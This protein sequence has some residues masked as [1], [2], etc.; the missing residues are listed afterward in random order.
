MVECRP[1]PKIENHIALAKKHLDHAIQLQSETCKDHLWS[2]VALFYALT[3]VVQAKLIQKHVSNLP[4]SH[5][6]R[7]KSVKKYLDKDIANSFVLLRQQSE[8]V[9][10]CPQIAIEMEKEVALQ[11]ILKEQ[12]KFVTNLFKQLENSNSK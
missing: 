11:K 2:I 7:F 9:R 6:K 1:N 5:N 10:Y 8:Y 12:T 4:K 3:H